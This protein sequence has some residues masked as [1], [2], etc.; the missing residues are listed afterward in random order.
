MWNI[1]KQINRNFTLEP[2]NADHNHI[3]EQKETFTSKPLQVNTAYLP[4]SGRVE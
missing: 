4:F 1:F 3:T 2:T